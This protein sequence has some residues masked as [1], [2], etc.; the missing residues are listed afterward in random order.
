[1][2]RDLCIKHFEIIYRGYIDPEY[3][4]SGRV[5]VKSD[6]YAFGVTILTIITR[7]KAWSVDGDSLIEYVSLH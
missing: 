1:M 7:R 3:L 4:R 5:S 2:F 6:V